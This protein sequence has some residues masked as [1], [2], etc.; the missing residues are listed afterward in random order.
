M[1]NS[2]DNNMQLDLDY[3]KKRLCEKFAEKME[4]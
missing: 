1:I 4:Y 2:F 3:V